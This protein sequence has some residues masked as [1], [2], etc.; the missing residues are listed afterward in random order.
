[1]TLNVDSLTVKE[2]TRHAKAAL[3]L[4]TGGVFVAAG[5]GIALTRMPSYAVAL[6]FAGAA[7]LHALRLRRRE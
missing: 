6:A 7:T 1:M 4:I 3:I 2:N 5:I